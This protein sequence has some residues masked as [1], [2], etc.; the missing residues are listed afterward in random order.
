MSCTS[1]NSSICSCSCDITSLPTGSDGLNG[2]NAYTRTTA[3]FV[4]PNVGD[5]VTINVSTL[6]QYTGEWAVLGQVVYIQ[7][8]GYYKVTAI[9]TTSLDVENL[10]YTGNA[11]PLTS[12][13]TNAAVSPAGLI[14]P[15]GATGATGATGPQ[16]IQGI[17]GPAGSDGMVYET[18][19]LH[20]TTT[21]FFET[22]TSIPLTAAYFIYPGST[23]TLTP[24]RIKILADDTSL[25]GQG[26]IRITDSTTGLNWISTTT[27]TPGLTASI[28]DL[29][30][31]SN[32]STTE[33]KILV[34]IFI[35]GV[36]HTIRVYSMSIQYA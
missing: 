13:T 21:R 14:G 6:G 35:V 1:C 26:K 18:M 19:L 11:A 3:G 28:I 31:P 34:E 25:T 2:Y 10:G 27:F 9:G 7:G 8:A 16:G 32:I 36:G 15:Q 24:V 29:G 22:S 17:Q 20:G 12:I 4:V 30:V 5:S 33:T 23:N